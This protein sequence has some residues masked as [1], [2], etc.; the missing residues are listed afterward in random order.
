MS[1]FTGPK[2]LTVDIETSPAEV[3]VWDIF[4]PTIG[5]N[6]IIKPT[7][8]ICFAAKWLHEPK[9][10]F[11]AEWL[12][13]Q[14]DMVEAAHRY[15]DEADVV[16]TYNGN[17]FDIP[18]LNREFDQWDLKEPAPYHSV[19]LYRVVKR[20]ERFLSHKL[21]Y[22]SKQLGL[23]GKMDSG[24]FQTWIDLASEDERTRKR[25]QLLMA[26]YNKQDVRTTEELYLR[27]LPKIHLPSRA[28][29]V[30]G[31]EENCPRPGCG[32]SNVQRRGFKTTLTRKYRRYQCQD[33]GGWFSETRSSGS[34]GTS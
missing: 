25:A 16:V 1:E 32:S 26:R 24:G 10:N 29:W 30:D 20:N 15:F 2:I 5:V 18:H 3:Y 17:N 11:H 19:D 8:V 6:Q 21:V 27:V 7:R 4:K 33:C 28:L 31:A 14:S 9:V 22:V 34:V 13:S 12:T 23:S